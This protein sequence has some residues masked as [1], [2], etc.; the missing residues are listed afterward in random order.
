MVQLVRVISLQLL[1]IDAQS[2]QEGLTYRKIEAK[3]DQVWLLNDFGIKNWLGIWY[4]TSSQGAQSVYCGSRRLCTRC[5]GQGHIW[6]YLHLAGKPDKWVHGEHCEL[7]K[8]VTSLSNTMTFHNYHYYFHFQ[9]PS[10]KTVIGLLD[11]YGFEVFNIN[12]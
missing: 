10:R 7:V 5:P 3:T 1:G 9:D 8:S 12:R 6:T 4:L 2:L 11:I